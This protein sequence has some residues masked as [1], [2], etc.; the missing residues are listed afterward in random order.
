[1]I[2]Q[3]FKLI[4]DFTVYDNLRFVLRATG[5]KDQKNMD[6][7]INEVLAQVNLQ[8][9]G[10]KKPFQLSGGEQQRVGIARALLNDPEIIIADEPTANLDPETSLK[11]MELLER[12]H[13][14]GKSI[15]MAT[16][17]YALILKF[18]HTT[19]KCENQTLSPIEIN[20]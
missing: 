12:I 10:F 8:N 3:D 7:Q 14:S 4:D 5:W 1:M 9:K 6:D 18:P 15:L 2:F 11:F 13:Q 19:Y 17:D 20:P 16:H